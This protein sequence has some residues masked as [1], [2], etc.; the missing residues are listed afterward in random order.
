MPDGFHGYGTILKVGNGASPEVFT[1]IAALRKIKIPGL[2]SSSIDVSH[3][4]TL[5]SIRRFIP[6]M[7]TAGKCGISGIYIPGDAS[8]GG[9]VSRQRAATISNYIIALSDSEESEVE[10][11]AF[12]SKTDPGE[13]GI[14]QL[15]EFSAELTLTGDNIVIP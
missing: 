3:L 13:A 7:I 12:V 8:Q 14:D 9:L 2:E 4:T 15:V 6:G 11:E 1:P 5:E 10:F